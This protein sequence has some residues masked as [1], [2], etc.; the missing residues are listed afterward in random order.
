MGAKVGTIGY[1]RVSATDQDFDGQVDR[2]KAAGAQRIFAEKVSGKSTNGRYELDKAIKALGPGD[3]LIVVRLGGSRAPS[4]ICS[5]CSTT[6]RPPTRASERS[7]TPGAIR[8]R[9]RAN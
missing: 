6:S 7:M 8:P 1:A 2:L 5:S 4:A 9:R 3:T